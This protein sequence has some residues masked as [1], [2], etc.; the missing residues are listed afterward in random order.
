[1]LYNC[2]VLVL[3]AFS[4]HPIIVPMIVDAMVIIMYLNIE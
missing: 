1:M 2:P 3:I 4:S